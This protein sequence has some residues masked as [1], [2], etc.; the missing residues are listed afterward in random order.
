MV[1]LYLALAKLSLEFSVHL[2]GTLTVK[3]EVR[4]GNQVSEGPPFSTGITLCE[5]L[6][7]TRCLSRCSVN[8]VE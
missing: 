1:L 5:K 2:R 6:K 8:Q 3:N 7:S 4:D